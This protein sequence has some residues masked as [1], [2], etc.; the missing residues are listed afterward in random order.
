MCSQ[1]TRHWFAR[2]VIV[3]GSTF[4]SR[5]CALR[6]NAAMPLRSRPPPALPTPA[7]IV[8]RDVHAKGKELGVFQ[9]QTAATSKAHEPAK[10]GSDAL[11]VKE[12]KD[13]KRIMSTINGNVAYQ[14][15]PYVRHAARLLLRLH[16]VLCCDTFTRS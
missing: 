13:N 16:T 4:E 6:D 9:Q 11:R 7:Q 15:P 14:Y 8:W 10:D 5:C 2:L 3:S 1:G 12:G